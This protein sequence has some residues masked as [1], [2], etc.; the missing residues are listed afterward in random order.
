[1][2]PSWF[3][4]ES[5]DKEMAKNTLI[6]KKKWGEAYKRGKRMEF[7]FYT[8]K[9]LRSRFGRVSRFVWGWGNHRMK[10]RFPDFHMTSSYGVFA[11][12][13][14]FW[15]TFNSDDAWASGF[16]SKDG[17]DNSGRE[18][19][20]EFVLKDSKKH[21]HS[22]CLWFRPQP[23]DRVVFLYT[24]KPNTKSKCIEISICMYRYEK[25]YMCINL[26]VLI[27]ARCQPPWHPTA[28]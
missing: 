5:T 2:K 28:R 9:W 20:K 10:F 26:C 19:F 1:M 12:V 7:R 18:G 27:H 4:F 14:M 16:Y 22:K 21:P 24:R 17:I 6:I 13:N 3:E 11:S 8:L 25:N 23:M 15:K